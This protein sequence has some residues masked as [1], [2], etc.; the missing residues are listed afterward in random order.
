M[1]TLT[2]LVVENFVALSGV[3]LRLL[4]SISHRDDCLCYEF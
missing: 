3:T 2:S 4:V 1:T